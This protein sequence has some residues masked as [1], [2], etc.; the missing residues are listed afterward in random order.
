MGYFAD[1][2]VVRN[3]S[4]EG[5]F[6]KINGYENRNKKDTGQTQKGDRDGFI[7]LSFWIT[8]MGWMKFCSMYSRKNV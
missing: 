6:E 4:R 8:C 2:N 5:R 1:R 3:K 7:I